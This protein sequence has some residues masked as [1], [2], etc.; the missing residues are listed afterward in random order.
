MKKR[1]KYTNEPMKLR[2]IPDF[3]PPP[4]RLRLKNARV[5]VTVEVTQE[6]VDFYRAHARGREYRE[7]M[8]RLLDLY[9]AQYR[10]SKAG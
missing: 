2:L 9:A 4:Q 8:A 3:L 10:K 6:S 7:M 1:I 5:K